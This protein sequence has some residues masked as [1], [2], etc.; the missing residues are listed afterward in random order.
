MKAVHL[1]V[2]RKKKK[3][4]FH[5]WPDIKFVLLILGSSHSLKVLTGDLGN[6]NLIGAT[7]VY[8]GIKVNSGNQK[9]REPDLKTTLLATY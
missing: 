6:G 1:Q 7:S 5:F 3:I 9:V 4:I 2:L 8:M